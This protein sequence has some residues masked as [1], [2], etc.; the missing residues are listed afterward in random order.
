[1][2][3]LNAYNLQ[4]QCCICQSQTHFSFFRQPHLWSRVCTR[5]GNHWGTVCNPS[6]WRGCRGWEGTHWCL[7]H[8]VL[9]WSQEGS[10]TCTLQPC[11]HRCHYFDTLAIPRGH[12]GVEQS[13]SFISQRT[14]KKVIIKILQ[15]PYSNL[16]ETKHTTIQRLEVSKMFVL[17]ELILSA[18]MH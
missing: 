16:C 2:R 14:P 17:K 1:M 13:S 4:L 10:Y 18:R 5:T 9:Q 11:P 7:P 3:L 6:C 15:W 8:S 12:E